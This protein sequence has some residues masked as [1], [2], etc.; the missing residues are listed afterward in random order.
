MNQLIPQTGQTVIIR[1]RP[2]II[3]DVEKSRTTSQEEIHGVWVD[4]ID[5]YTIPE[6]EY[7]IWEI[8]HNPK[9]ISG[10]NLPDVASLN[11]VDPPDFFHAYLNS[12]RWNAINRI[13]NLFSNSVEDYRLI[14][15]WYSAVQ[16]EQYQLLPV[17]KALNMPRIT[18]LLADDV[19]LGKTI[20]AGLVVNELIARG[21]LH[22]ILIICPASLQNQWAEEMEEKFYLDFQILTR[23]TTFNYQ[24]D[25]GIDSNAWSSFPRIITSIDYLRQG[26]VLES[27]RSASDTFSREH[28]ASLPWDLLIIDEAHNISSLYFGEETERLRMI[29]QVL[30]YFEN[31]LF[32]T[33]TPHNGYTE[34]FSGILE[35]LN[36]LVFEQKRKLEDN[37]F[38][39]I[40][41][42]VVRRLKSDFIDTGLINKFKKRYINR[43]DD[44]YKLNDSE[45]ELYEALKRYKNKALSI[46]PQDSPKRLMVVKF[47]LTLL[48][49]RLLSSVYAFSITWWNHFAGSQSDEI[50]ERDID[51]VLKRVDEDIS[52]D[53][54]K[55]NRENEAV[56]KIG[57]WLAQNKELLKKEINEINELLNQLGW[58]EKIINTDISKV[59]IF[60]EDSKWITLLQWLNKRLKSE[61]KFREDERVIIFTEYKNT[62]DYLLQKFKIDGLE[63]PV[64]SSLFG[65]TDQTDRNDIKTYFN[66]PESPLKILAATDA[67]SEGL[68]LQKNCRYVIH[69]DIPW[70]P[71]RLEQRNG[72][73]DRFGQNRDVEIFHYASDEEED[74]QFL[75]RI[76]KKIQQIRED[77]GSAGEL[78]DRNIEKHFMGN[79]EDRA[80]AGKDIEAIQPELLLNDDLK[81]ITSITD[82]EYTRVF[83]KLKATEKELNL[84]PANVAYIVQ[85][86][87][88]LEGGKLSKHPIENDVYQIDS[89]PPKWDNIISK[90]LKIKKGKHAG[91]L[92]KLVFNPAYFEKVEHGL[93][94]YLNKPD[95]KLLRLG[96]PIVKRAIGLFKRKMWSVPELK[97]EEGHLNKF[98]VKKAELVSG[99]D[100]IVVIHC[101]I[102]ST[103]ELKETIHQEVISIPGVIERDKFKNINEELW[104]NLK[105][106]Q[107]LELR[108]DQLSD[109]LP[110]IK[111]LWINAEND[112]KSYLENRGNEIKKDFEK[113]L[114]QNLETVKKDTSK[115]YDER[116]KELK[117]RRGAKYLI[118]L[119]G[120]IEQEKLKLQQQVLF[121]DFNWARL[122][123]IREMEI[124]LEK[125]IS[126]RVQYLEQIIQSEKDKM[127]KIVIPR[128]YKMQ[129]F[130][131]YPLGIEFLLNSNLMRS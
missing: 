4:Y 115:L 124:D 14:S 110:Q 96:H 91:A 9:I 52:D 62:L 76:V 33:A 125:I 75:E 15:P 12:I 66:D 55:A 10:S 101:L 19:G 28:E 30:P 41:K 107:G 99:I 130:K 109:W 94:I 6:S 100:H 18:M 108:S 31:R 51:L 59:K 116:L 65:G 58:N 57:S 131:L 72:R 17:V 3:R 128:K 67:A 42:Y 27:F 34:S 60:S 79:P 77:L 26:D 40:D 102:E 69:Y 93:M 92:Y 119:K 13:E 61:G 78:I 87:F 89:V 49:K 21:K 106:N 37:D 38:R 104:N 5:G 29:K 81:K 111:N 24:K 1:N 47:L 36:P 127:I 129:F 48:T 44:H 84:T 11:M 74:L 112:I 85:N 22:R 16:V 25:F 118:K 53:I 8:E 7:I 105:S 113:K 64:I 83:Q 70:N 2:G 95:A 123:K 80:S 35:L 114:Q 97:Y 45:K 121:E 88:E 43:I 63:E 98:T 90:T 73:V 39:F 126:D 82:E 54:E 32:L 86:S 46:V 50:D 23:N 103:N 71:I 120:Q 56:R 68:N 20:E 122:D 117:E